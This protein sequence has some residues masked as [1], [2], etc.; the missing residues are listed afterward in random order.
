MAFQLNKDNSGSISKKKASTAFN[1]GDFL[2]VDSDGFLIPGGAGK[3]VGISN[4]TVKS[5]DADYAS[6]RDLNF[7]EAQD[8]VEFIIPVATGTATQTLVGELVDVDATDKG[9][10]DVTAS[11]NDQ[12]RITRVINASTVYGKIV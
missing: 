5:T 12:I 1:V 8:D 6:T 2:T 9:A 7:T 10:V 4:E 3:V 11:T